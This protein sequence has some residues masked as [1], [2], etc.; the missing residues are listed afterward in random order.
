MNYIES[1]AAE[2]QFTGADISKAKSILSYKPDVNLE[3]GI[4]DFIQWFQENRKTYDS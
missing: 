4:Y 2:M 3:E 1:K